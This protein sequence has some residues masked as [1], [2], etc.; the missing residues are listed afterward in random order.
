M[1]TKVKE[2]GTQLN[3]DALRALT[4]SSHTSAVVMTYLALRQRNRRYSN[5]EVTKNVLL[6][7]GEKIDPKEY[8]DFWKSLEKIGIG[9]YKKGR[10]VNPDTFSWKYSLKRIAGAAIEGKNI[11]VEPMKDSVIHK[12]P[13][14]SMALKKNAIKTNKRILKF[15]VRHVSVQNERVVKIHLRANCDIEMRIPS[16]FSKTDAERVSKSLQ[17]LAK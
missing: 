14:K 4:N 2:T 11:V 3:G 16:D 1:N 8:S 12:T 17:Y 7:K 10:G 6:A 9:T 5:V 13:L 15:G